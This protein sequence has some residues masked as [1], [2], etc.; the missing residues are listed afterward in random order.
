[1]VF[2]MFFLETGRKEINKNRSFQTSRGQFSGQGE[3]DQF[4]GA[5]RAV[6]AY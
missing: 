3:A 5:F 1:L 6:L 2:S 4:A